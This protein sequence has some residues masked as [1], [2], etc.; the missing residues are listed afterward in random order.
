MAKGGAK[1]DKI[2][3]EWPGDTYERGHAVGEFTADRQGSL[4]PFGDE[5]F[6]LPQDKV[7]YTHPE[8]VINR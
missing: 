1:S 3:P 7:P 2:D 6:P 8:T 4:S 5:L